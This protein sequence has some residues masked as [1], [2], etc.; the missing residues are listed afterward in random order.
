MLST[1]L[2][3]QVN[4]KLHQNASNIAPLR[5][6]QAA[7][8]DAHN[9]LNAE[10]C[11]LESLDN[12]LSINEGIL[13]NSIR[14]CNAVIEASKSTPAPNIDEVLVAPT[15]ASQQLWN[16]CADDA[17]IREALWCLQR[18]V[19]AGRVSGT[20]FV[21]LTRGLARESFLKMALIRKVARG[22][23]LDL[24]AANSGS[25]SRQRHSYAGI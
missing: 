8:Q 7:L 5:T 24:E 9:R 13:H 3:G 22:L 23:G 4:A 2:V 6:Q 25:S 12:V 19:G 11:H 20:D 1:T 14:D 18:A 17:A 10:L 21:R 16:L 15:V